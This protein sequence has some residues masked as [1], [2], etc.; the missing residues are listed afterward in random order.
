M[1]L[2]SYRQHNLLKAY[3][4]PGSI[5]NTG[6][7]SLNKVKVPPLVDFQYFERKKAINMQ[8]V[9]IYSHTYRRSKTSAV[10]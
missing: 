10:N 5:I 6:V 1:H 2:N 4:M 8:D 7:I 9:C 3:Y